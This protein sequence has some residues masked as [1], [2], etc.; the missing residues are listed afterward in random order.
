MRIGEYNIVDNVDCEVNTYGSKKCNGPVQDLGIEKIIPHPDYN[1]TVIS[2]D[3][4]L[5][6]VSKMN[7]TTGKFYQY[8]KLMANFFFQ[9]KL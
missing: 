4:G 5:I 1:Y 9:K 8:F 2:N 7:L 6:R 3:I